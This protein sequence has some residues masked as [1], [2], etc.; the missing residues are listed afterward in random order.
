MPNTTTGPAAPARSFSHL[1]SWHHGQNPTLRIIAVPRRLRGSAC[2]S[3]RE[4]ARLTQGVAGAR[5]G[6]VRMRENIENHDWARLI[7]PERHGSHSA[8]SPGAGGLVGG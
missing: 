4:R 7:Q 8:R 1:D 5:P 3:D 6:V 2:V